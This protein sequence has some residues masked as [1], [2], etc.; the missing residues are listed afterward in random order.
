MFI[1]SLKPWAV[2]LPDS[3]IKWAVIFNLLLIKEIVY[4]EKCL[5]L[6]DF[7]SL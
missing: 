7:H 6:S 2:S 3:L 1:F 4:A 5:F